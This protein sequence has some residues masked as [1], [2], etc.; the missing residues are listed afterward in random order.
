[1]HNLCVFWFFCSKIIINQILFVYCCNNFDYPGSIVYLSCFGDHDHVRL[2]YDVI[3]ISLCNCQK[4]H[5]TQINRHCLKMILTKFNAFSKST[6][7]TLCSSTI[8]DII[9]TL[10]NDLKF[11]WIQLAVIE[12]ISRACFAILFNQLNDLNWP[13]S[14]I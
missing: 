12:V 2:Y 4:E 1:M 5:H 10:F 3:I 9:F 14:S 6:M 7:F 13:K 8:N 11:H